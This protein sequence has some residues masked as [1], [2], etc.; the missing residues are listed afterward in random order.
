[1]IGSWPSSSRLEYSG[2]AGIAAA[3]GAVECSKQV[4]YSV[5][6][7]M[8]VVYGCGAEIAVLFRLIL[9]ESGGGG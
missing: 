4:K 2:M 8:S 1:M 6:L 3:I 7:F 5:Y 9:W